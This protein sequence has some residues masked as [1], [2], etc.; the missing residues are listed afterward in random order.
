MD[1]VHIQLQYA[2]RLAEAQKGSKVGLCTAFIAV[3][4][5]LDVGP[6]LRH[7]NTYDT[8]RNRRES[9]L[10][11]EAAEL[12]TMPGACLRV[13]VHSLLLL[14]PSQQAPHMQLHADKSGVKIT[15]C[16]ATGHSCNMSLMV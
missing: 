1:L 9:A 14:P 10:P 4:K 2:G 7:N 5:F 6:S 16:C 3:H 12:C 15:G 11:V 8:V 13:L